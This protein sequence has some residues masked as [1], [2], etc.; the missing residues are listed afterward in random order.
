MSVESIY[1]G[2]KTYKFVKRRFIRRK[3]IYYIMKTL[4]IKCEGGESKMSNEELVFVET[5]AI[6]S[7]NRGKA[8][9][10]WSE[11]FAK[12]PEGQSLVIPESYGVGATVRSAVQKVNETSK[13][14]YKV[15][16]RQEGK[17]I[18]IY[19]SRM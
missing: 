13:I 5:S 11:L 1:L 19:V 14:Q 7:L 4:T 2:Q 10:N 16:Q 15:T 6:P 9:R 12:I 17:K 8:G 18:I 3:C